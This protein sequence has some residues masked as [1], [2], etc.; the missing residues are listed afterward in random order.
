M[1]QVCSIAYTHSA[2]GSGLM[3]PFFLFYVFLTEKIE[4]P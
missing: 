2:S 1:Q 4:L 3:H